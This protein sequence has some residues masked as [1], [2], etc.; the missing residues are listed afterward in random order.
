MILEILEH[1]P[2]LKDL[3][4]ANSLKEYLQPAFSWNPTTFPNRSMLKSILVHELTQLYKLNELETTLLQKQLDSSWCIQTGEHIW[5]PRVRE[6]V[7]QKFSESGTLLPS[8]NPM[9]FQGSILWS[10]MTRANGHSFSLLAGTGRVP[11]NNPISGSH[12]EISRDLA[13]LRLVSEKWHSSPQLFVPAINKNTLKSIELFLL[14][15]QQQ[16]SINAIEAF[17]FFHQ[18][19]M[20]KELLFVDQIALAHSHL[21]SRTNP[22]TQLTVE[23]ERLAVKFIHKLLSDQNTI[24]YNVF[25]S[26]TLRMEFVNKLSNIATGWKAT[27]TP[28]LIVNTS[29]KTPTLTEYRGTLDVN[30]I[31]QL[32][33][34]GALFPKGVLKFFVFMLEG[35]LLPIGGMCQRVYC[36]EIRD[37]SVE[38]LRDIKEYKLADS[39]TDMPTQIATITPCW[40]LMHNNRL[41]DFLDCLEKPISKNQLQDTLLTTGEQAI[42][43]AALTLYPFLTGKPAR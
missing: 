11:I 16:L 34:S 3:L 32:L 37:R 5:L 17:S 9:V 14:K 28:F 29:S 23:S 42:K 4:E 35:G 43:N 22:V 31:K 25:A 30:T 20:D 36:S 40:G 19:L 21:I 27:D 33:F 1:R 39:L 10:A 7:K 12:L 2:G 26:P 6:G 41:T 18:E 8:H 13:M 15:N 24:T 38:L